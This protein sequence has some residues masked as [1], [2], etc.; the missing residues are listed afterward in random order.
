MQSVFQRWPSAS[1]F[2]C[3]TAGEIYGTRVE[4]DSIVC[5]AIEFESARLVTHCRAVDPS[6]DG[7]EAGVQLAEAL[8]TSGLRHV[9][10]LSDGTHVN[11]TALVQGL[12]TALPEGV[13]VTGGLSGDGAA[14]EK[15]LVLCDR[16]V[17]SRRVAIAALYGDALEIGF[18]SLGGWDPFGPERV[19]TRSEGN[20]LYELDG[21]SALALYEKYLGDHAPGLPA[22]GLLFPLALRQHGSQTTVVRT[23]LGIDRAS[24]SM[25]FAGDLPEGSY[26]RLMKANF[27]R[28]I[29]GAMG[30]AEK[31][32]VSITENQPE[33]GLLISCV[34]RKMVLKQRIEEEIEGV[35]E[36]LGSGP[37]LSGFY[38]YGE[39]SPHGVGDCEL[40][41][42]TMTIT[43]LSERSS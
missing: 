22:T 18:G 37:V 25:T 33:L 30:A 40:H 14:F 15:T 6:E 28:L 32:L 21:Q 2:G 39:I 9:L 29:D 5:T 4:D 34:G 7:H 13:S 43:T 12:A 8:E 27:D 10:V 41:N 24:Q 36:V 19:I 38:S 23:I 11:G 3:T 35:R 17:S 20:I 16:S 1:F 26:A 31:S 42:Q